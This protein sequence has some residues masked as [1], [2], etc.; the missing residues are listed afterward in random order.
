MKTA[1]FQNT[2]GRKIVRKRK[3]A[4]GIKLEFFGE[5]HHKKLNCFCCNSL[6][7]ILRLEYTIADHCIGCVI[8]INTVAPNIPDIVAVNIDCPTVASGRGE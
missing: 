2:D 1:F 4:D 7:P 8:V 6:I 5:F 3:G